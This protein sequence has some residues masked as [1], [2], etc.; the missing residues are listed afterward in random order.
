MDIYQTNIQMLQADLTKKTDVDRVIQGMDIVLQAAAA[1]SG[2]KDVA[3]KPD[4]VVL[5][6]KSN[7][8]GSL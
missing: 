4:G 8:A 3:D 2:I 5:L 6:L 1:T 7:T